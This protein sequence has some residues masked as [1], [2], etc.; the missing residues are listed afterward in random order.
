MRFALAP[1]SPALSGLFHISFRQAFL[2]LTR[3]E[4]RY[5][6]RRRLDDLPPERLRDM[7]LKGPAPRLK[8]PLHQAGGS[9]W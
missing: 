6:D 3:T 2:Y 4:A 9:L 1:N 8:N 7:G 5:R